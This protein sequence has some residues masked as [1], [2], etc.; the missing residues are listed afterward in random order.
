M[1]LPLL[2]MSAV[3]RYPTR[4]VQHADLKLTA[5]MVAARQLWLF[6]HDKHS[7]GQDNALIGLFGHP[8]EMATATDLFHAA[9]S[10]VLE[11]DGSG[12]VPAGGS[13]HTPCFTNS[14]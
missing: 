5:A 3:L 11:R 4:R 8:S 13:S 7:H 10:Q 14:P 1:I 6:G 12:G 2:A 9:H